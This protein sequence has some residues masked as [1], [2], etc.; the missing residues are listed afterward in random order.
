MKAQ[1]WGDGLRFAACVWL[2]GLLASLA[3]AAPRLDADAINN[4]VWDRA[5]IRSK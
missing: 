2:F 4:A 3:Q 5:A 1:R